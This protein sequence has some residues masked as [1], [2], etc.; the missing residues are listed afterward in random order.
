[1]VFTPANAALHGRKG[2]KKGGKAR[3][4]QLS[5]KERQAI[6]RKG[7]KARWA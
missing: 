1:M 4:K 6:A 3:A 7:G 2:G 5:A